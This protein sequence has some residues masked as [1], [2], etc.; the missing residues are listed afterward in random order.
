MAQCGLINHANELTIGDKCDASLP[1]R[2][3]ARFDIAAMLT[4]SR[5]IE[6]IAIAVPGRFDRLG[7]H[8]RACAAKNR[9]ALPAP[10]GVPRSSTCA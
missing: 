10:A 7:C 1:I 8:A 2:E 4:T 9:R 6:L 5:I 3:C